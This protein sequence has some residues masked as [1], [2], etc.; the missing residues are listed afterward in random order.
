MERSNEYL[1]KFKI[2][3]ANQFGFPAGLSTVSAVQHLP[4]YLTQCIENGKYPVDIF[5]DL[6]RAFDLL[7]YSLLLDK[8][9]GIRGAVLN[10]INSFLS[11]RRQYVSIRGDNC[12]VKSE[13]FDINIGVPRGRLLSP[14]LFC[15]FINDLSNY[16]KIPV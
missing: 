13:L 2:I 5:C 8:C 9:Y 1:N 15:L 14:T 4:N 7:S 16:T 3:S 6:S 12:D 10:W 11:A